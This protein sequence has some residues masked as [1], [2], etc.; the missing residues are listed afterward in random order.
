[1]LTVLESRPFQA[2][3]LESRPWKSPSG[4]SYWYNWFAIIYTNYRWLD[5]DKQTYIILS[6]TTIKYLLADA[7]SEILSCKL[8]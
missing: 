2:L 5:R 6:T 3:P 7:F 4:L 8:L 1:M